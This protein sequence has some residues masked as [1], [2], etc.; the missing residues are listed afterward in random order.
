M[1]SRL[2]LG[3]RKVGTLRNNGIN[4]N[5]VRKRKQRVKMYANILTH[6]ESGPRYFN[7]NLE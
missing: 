5:F 6:N 3:S 4:K 2:Q 1:S 7:K